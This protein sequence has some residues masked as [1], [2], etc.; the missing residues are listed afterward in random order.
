MAA[1][2][3]GVTTRVILVNIA[4]TWLDPNATLLLA[5]PELLG[6]EATQTAVR[7]AFVV[8]ALPSP[9][10]SRYLLSFP[11]TCQELGAPGIDIDAEGCLSIDDGLVRQ[12]T[13]TFRHTVVYDICVS[14]V[15]V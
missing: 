2:Q 6:R 12:P 1:P 11:T 8:P 10:C 14:L 5:N 9:T 7:Y 13:S 3:I 15:H 4:T